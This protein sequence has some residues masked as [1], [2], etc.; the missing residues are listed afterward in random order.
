[1]KNLLLILTVFIAVSCGSRDDEPTTPPAVTYTQADAVGTWKATHYQ[2]NLEGP[3]WHVEK[4]NRTI[5]YKN[6]ANFTSYFLTESYTVEMAGKYSIDG[7][8]N[9]STSNVNYSDRSV[10]MKLTSK[11]EAILYIN[12]SSDAITRKYKVVKQ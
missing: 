10:S 11:T 12:A 4:N 2:R 3:D 7:S 5:T 1:M 8:G 6:D 9:I